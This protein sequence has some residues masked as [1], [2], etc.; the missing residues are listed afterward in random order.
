MLNNHNVLTRG[1]LNDNQINR[2]FTVR[3]IL[4]F[5]VVLLRES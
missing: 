3:K 1:T 4:I 2:D 5:L